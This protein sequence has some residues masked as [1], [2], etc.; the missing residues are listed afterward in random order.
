M[1]DEYPE[2]NWNIKFESPPVGDI[3]HG[4]HGRGKGYDRQLYSTFLFD[5]YTDADIIGIIDSDV[6]ILSMLTLD[7]I[8]DEQGRLILHKT[9]KNDVW[10]G[11]VKLFPFPENGNLCDNMATDRFPA[12]YWR[13]AFKNTRDYLM[14][15]FK[16][17]TFEDAFSKMSGTGISPANII[18]SVGLRT[19]ENQDKY[20]S[21]PTYGR[22]TI[23]PGENKI[24]GPNHHYLQSYSCCSIFPD[25]PYCDMLTDSQFS[26]MKEFFV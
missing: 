24:P 17:D 13:D 15:H 12:F 11:D 26:E 7:T 18:C 2:F 1:M 20:A 4:R 9:H 6:F 25:V 23:A 10:G 3:F 22:A 14:D 21:R 8:F 16:V 5:N 19:D